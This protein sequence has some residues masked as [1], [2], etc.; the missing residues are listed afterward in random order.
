MKCPTHKEFDLWLKDLGKASAHF[1]NT[2]RL[3]A[4]VLLVLILPMYIGLDWILSPVCDWVMM[5]FHPLIYGMFLMALLLIF[6]VVELKA[7]DSLV[8]IQRTRAKEIK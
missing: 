7:M 8:K 4:I 6:V 1:W 2:Q 5:T 3:K